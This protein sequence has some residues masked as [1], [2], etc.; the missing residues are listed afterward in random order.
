MRSDFS[1][2]NNNS[3]YILRTYVLCYRG[4]P[5]VFTVERAYDI[6]KAEGSC[7]TMTKRTVRI[8]VQK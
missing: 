8:I 6:D 4:E 5:W 3:A 7:Q 2:N 1:L